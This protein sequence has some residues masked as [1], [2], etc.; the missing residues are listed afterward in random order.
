MSSFLCEDYE[1][2]LETFFFYASECRYYKYYPFE[3]QATSLHRSLTPGLSQRPAYHSLLSP[4]PFSSP[5][6]IGNLGLTKHAELEYILREWHLFDIEKYVKYIFCR[7]LLDMRFHSCTFSHRYSN[8]SY[9]LDGSRVPQM[10]R[11]PPVVRVPSGG[12]QRQSENRYIYINPRMGNHTGE[13]SV[14]EF[15]SKISVT[16]LETQWE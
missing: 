2:T 13:I 16:L 12:N 3:V 1:V 7:A 14:W 9:R 15:S 4:I 6:H 5:L 10:V 8:T 11:V